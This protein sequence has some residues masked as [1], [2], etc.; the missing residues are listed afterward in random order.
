MFDM[1]N[2]QAPSVALTYSEPQ[3]LLNSRGS[4][5]TRLPQISQLE[6]QPTM[7]ASK[8]TEVSAF[9]FSLPGL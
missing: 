1:S 2:V 8:V 9:P 5:L 3:T 6:C 4:T 7:L